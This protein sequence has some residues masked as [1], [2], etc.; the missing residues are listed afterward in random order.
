MQNKL[1]G[2]V[3]VVVGLGLLYWGYS[4][5]QSVTSQVSEAFSGSPLDR[6]MYKY[7]GGALA[8]AIGLYLFVKK[9]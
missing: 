5:S 7:I 8:L 6:V 1:I 4:E 9:R 3:L 2:I